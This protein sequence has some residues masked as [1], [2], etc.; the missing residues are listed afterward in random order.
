[1]AQN[2]IVSQ[3]YALACLF[4]VLLRG[5]EYPKRLGMMGT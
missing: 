2:E 5:S 1:M 4:D 3:L